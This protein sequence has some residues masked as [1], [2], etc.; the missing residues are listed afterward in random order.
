MP[1][2]GSAPTIQPKKPYELGGRTMQLEIEDAP[3]TK[4]DLERA[5]V[6]FTEDHPGYGDRHYSE[7]RAHIAA[8]L[9]KWREGDEPPE[10]PYHPN[11][12][13][14]WRVIA[15]TLSDKHYMHASKEILDAKGDF[16]L[17]HDRVPQL[18]E[19][20]T[21][22]KELTGFKFEP[23]AGVV[24]GDEFYRAFSRDSF[25][26]TQYIRHHSEPLFSPEPDM[27]HEVIGHGTMLA[28]D[29]F[30]ALYRLVGQA[31][32]RVTTD[33][34]IGLISRVFWFTM[35]C[36]V[37]RERG[38][39]KAYGASLLSSCGEIEGIAKVKLRRLEIADVLSQEY[40][41][42]SYQPVLFYAESMMHLED[43]LHRFCSVV[44]DD[45]PK[46]LKG[47]ASAGQ[48]FGG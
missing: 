16:R 10:I 18:A 11:D 19:A 39:Y 30:A 40:D 3:V 13:D 25:F 29:H 43:L 15:R 47:S 45:T 27:V 41:I 48:L 12:H 37:I 44:D 32:Q 33:E 26:A 6:T 28:H 22:L 2:G 46:L 23:A 4:E 21:L 31:A 14:T 8:T 38:E 36:G 34:A 20:S 42:S 35:E 5:T 9:L 24:P 1:L 17:P 7:R